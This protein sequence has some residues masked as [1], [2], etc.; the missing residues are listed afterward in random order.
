MANERVNASIFLPTV[1]R[2]PGDAE[3]RHRKLDVVREENLQPGLVVA[4][5]DPTHARGEIADQQIERLQP[6]ITDGTEA[7]VMASWKNKQGHPLSMLTHPNETIELLEQQIDFASS[8]REAK[9]SSIDAPNIV[10]T[11]HGS[12]YFYHQLDF[13]TQFL[14]PDFREEQ[15]LDI[16]LPRLTRLVEYGKS[17]GV[18][19]LIE[20][21]PQPPFSDWPPS[22]KSRLVGTDFHYHDL[23]TPWPGLPGGRENEGF[24]EIGLGLVPDW[25]HIE[26]GARSLNKVAEIAR[27]R[28]ELKQAAMRAY[29]F[30]EADLERV[31]MIHNLDAEILGMT[32]DG[33]V[34]HASNSKG[35]VKKKAVDGSD[36]AYD[37]EATLT[38]PK[39]NIT[40]SQIETLIRESL[41]K[42][43]MLVIEVGEDRDKMEEAPNA[44]AALNDL[45]LPIAR[46]IQT[47]HFS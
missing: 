9:D 25:G 32:M 44:M 14:D 13:A 10:L 5:L 23:V 28:P 21:V 43:V 7:L 30:A 39:T 33:D 11:F 37:D 36:Q 38:D 19:L 46:K 45:V 3:N 15:F 24:R 27:T 40:P 17:K 26:I 34:V 20:T 22:E 47:R 6:L 16:A 8:V 31:D 41:V 35:E 29:M 4:L 18:D 2:F 42:R 1:P 12:F